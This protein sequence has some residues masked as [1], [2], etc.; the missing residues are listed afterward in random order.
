MK[1]N[2]NRGPS[3]TDTKLCIEV[4][5]VKGLLIADPSHSAWLGQGR[6][7]F[8]SGSA[9]LIGRMAGSSE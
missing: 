2:G 1:P 5:G 3:S 4:P 9:D 8:T 6:G 7:P